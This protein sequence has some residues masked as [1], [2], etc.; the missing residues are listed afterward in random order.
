MALLPRAAADMQPDEAVSPD[1]FPW[2]LLV[3]IHR[4][5]HGCI[6]ISRVWDIAYRGM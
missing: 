2:W 5:I 3:G 6:G 1:H 4:G